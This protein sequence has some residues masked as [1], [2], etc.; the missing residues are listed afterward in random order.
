MWHKGPIVNQWQIYK[1]VIKGIL[2]NVIIFCNCLCITLTNSMARVFS[3][4]TANNSNVKG[5]C[6]QPGAVHWIHP[7]SM[8]LS[9]AHPGVCVNL[10]VFLME[11]CRLFMK[12]ALVGDWLWEEMHCQWGDWKVTLDVALLKCTSVFNQNRLNANQVN[13]CWMYRIFPQVIGVVDW[14]MM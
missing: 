14:V 10:T 8:L 3:I 5:K 12:I 7:V 2:R 13:C 9:G 4:N 6:L 1:A 11:W